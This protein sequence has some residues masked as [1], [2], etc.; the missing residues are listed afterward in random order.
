MTVVLFDGAIYLGQPQAG[1]L[2]RLLGGEEGIKDVGLHFRQDTE[3]GVGHR[4]AYPLAGFHLGQ[5]RRVA[6]SESDPFQSKV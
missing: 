4:Q 1:A 2:A 3:T 6:L 5:G